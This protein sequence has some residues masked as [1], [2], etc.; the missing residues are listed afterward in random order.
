MRVF[1]RHFFVLSL[2]PSDMLMV[3][4]F[5]SRARNIHFKAR[6]EI[7]NHQHIGRH[8]G[9]NKKMPTKNPQGAWPA[10]K[11][12]HSPDIFRIRHRSTMGAFAGVDGYRR[13]GN[14]VRRQNNP[15]M[16]V[17]CNKRSSCFRCM[18]ACKIVRLKSD[19]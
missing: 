6:R 14:E 3:A 13:N 1:C 19:N 17:H 4:D 11:Q 12:A 2:M 8:Q 18:E 15:T 9:Q 16:F 5:P 7:G 10:S